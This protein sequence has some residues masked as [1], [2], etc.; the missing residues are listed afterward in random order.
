[1][2]SKTGWVAVLVRV[3]AALSAV[4]LSLLAAAQPASAATPNAWT[5][6]G[7]LATARSEAVAGVLPS[8]KVIVAGGDGG[9]T[10]SPL[11]SSEIFDPAT[12]TWSPGPSMS[13]A[14]FGAV[15]VTLPNGN[16]LVAGGSSNGTDDGVATA[17][18]YSPATNTFTPVAN[19]MSAGRFFP[20]AAL[21]SNGDVLIV[22]G[23][24]A[25]G[26]TVASADIYDPATN[27]FLTGAVAPR[28]MTTPRV[29]PMAARLS[30][31]N[32]LVAGGDTIGN[33]PV[34]SAE[35]YNP[36]ANTWTP[37]ATAMSSPR[38]G[39]GVVALAGGGAL[40][41]GGQSQTTPSAAS[42]A[43]TDIYNAFTNSFIPGPPMLA[44]RALFGMVT[45]PG[46]NV[47]VA[48]GAQQAAGSPASFTADSEVYNPT[49]NAWSSTGPLLSALGEFTTTVL[50]SGQVLEAGGANGTT[51]T[52]QTTQAS[53]YTPVSAP[54]APT[55]V[56]A[57]SGNRSALVTWVPPS[58]DGGAAIT[59]YTVV[60]ST[61]QTVTTPDGRTFITV[62]GLARGKAVTFTV[63]ATNPAGLGPASAPS[64]AVTAGP[65]KPPTLRLSSLARRLSLSRFLK[66]LTFSVKPDKAAAL[67]ITLLGT[68]DRATIAAAFDLTL[69][70]K[71]LKLSAAKRRVKLVP[72]RRLV[73]HPR[74]ARV[75]LE[76]VATD[77]AGTRSTTRRA[78]TIRS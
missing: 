37:A 41:A 40:V 25:A 72:N 13:A 35:V 1:M 11:A 16:L 5:A 18:V 73:G 26:T 24:D 10:G 71:R 69:A 57:T 58:N 77:A 52:S 23:D 39:G 33:A 45:L 64:N 59:S 34:A 47:L 53:V 2:R 4:M 54:A 20:G 51:A 50:Q 30:G 43:S 67:Q 61:G 55:G 49:T 6:V 19:T 75:R 9:T 36:T 60:A 66:G 46:G 15:G 14:R 12:G 44:S 27:M 74:T 63:R 38:A 78:V 65:D 21:L 29:L 22:G 42:T 48:G 17:E 31:G 7:S 32:V 28:S 62:G 3:G 76:I 68:V 56:T 8:G 70:T